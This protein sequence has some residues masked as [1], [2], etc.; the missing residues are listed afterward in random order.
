MSF[1]QPLLGIAALIGFGWLI[2]TDRRAVRWRPVF[3]GLALQWL[4][5]LLCWQQAQIREG[6]S[7]S[8]QLF[9]E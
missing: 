7:A 5:A 4:L 1:L 6:L 2:S 3:A 8:L 9:V